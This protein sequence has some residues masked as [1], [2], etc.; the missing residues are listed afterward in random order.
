MRSPFSLNNHRTALRLETLD[1]RFT[2]G[3]GNLDPSFGTG[4]FVTAP[5]PSDDHAVAVA[6]QSDGKIVLASS[7]FNGGNKDFVVMRFSSEGAPDSAFGNNGRVITQVGSGDDVAYALAIQG[8]G[9]IVVA[10]PCLVGGVFQFGVVRYNSNGSLDPSFGTGGKVTTPVGTGTD[11]ASA[12]AIQADGKIV[13]AGTASNGANGFD[14]AAVRYK[15]NGNL[16]STFGSGGKVLTPLNGYEECR[17]A[18]ID[19]DGKI[20]LAGGTEGEF[21][22]VRYNP[23][24]SLDASFDSDGKAVTQIGMSA[25]A[26]ALVLTAD[27]KYL[28]A[29][30][31]DNSFA[32]ARYDP[33]GGLDSSFGENG[34]VVTQLGSGYDFSFAVSLDSGGKIIAAGRSLNG[35]NYNFAVVRY[36]LNGSLDDSFDADGKVITDF[37]FGDDEARAVAI[38]SDGKILVGGTVWNGSAYQ[39]AVARYLDDSFALAPGLASLIFTED[40][41]ALTVD[42]NLKLTNSPNS[43]LVGATVQIDNYLRTE[44]VLGYTLQGGITANFNSLTGL[45]TFSGSAGIADYQAVLQSLSYANTSQSPLEL[46]RVLTVTVND[47]EATQN[48][49]TASYTIHVIAHNDAPGFADDGVLAP[50]GQQ[51]IVLSGQK[52]LSIFYKLDTDPDSGDYF[53]GLAVVGNSA[54]AATQGNWQYSTN[55][56][57]AWF[58]IGVVADDLTA[59]ALSAASRVRFVPVSTFVGQPAPLVVRAIDRTFAHPFTDGA[60][61]QTVDVTSNGETTSIAATTNL[62][63]TE[64]FPFGTGNIP[65]NLL[66]VPVSANINEGESLSFAASANDPDL[67]Q[68]LTFSLDGAPAAAS[69]DPDTGVFSWTTTEADGPDTFVFNVQVTDG[70]AVTARTVTVMVHEVNVAPT[71][72]GVPATVSLVRGQTLT[73]TANA[74]DPDVLNG[75]SNALSFTVDGSPPTITVGPVSAVV[76][77]WLS[78]D[79]RTGETISGTI[80]VSDDGVPTKTDAKTVE[81]MA[82]DCAIVNGDLVI[83]GT[84]KNDT[85]AVKP[86]KDDTQLI[87]VLNRKVVGAAPIANVTGRIVVH[88]LGGNDKITISPKITK[89]ADLHGDIGNDVLKGGGGDDRLFGNADDDRLTGGV[90]NDLLVGGE[91]NDRLVDTVGANVLFGGSG[92]DRLIGGKGQDLLL[93]GPTD[94]DNDLFALGNV[95]AEWTSSSNYSDRIMHLTGPLGGANGTTFLNASTVH[96]DGAKDVLTGAKEADY[97]IVSAL[98]KI[99]LKADEQKLEV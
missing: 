26:R 57:G 22:L 6:V 96:D 47:G 18:A 78:D 21:A 34:T 19:T 53:N 13:V 43:N 51:N 27:G 94:F 91:G 63:E 74:T 84:D 61:R 49:A 16:D 2:P 92:A 10:G 45:L 46:D 29:G 90:G 88:G 86:S 35:S 5:G 79:I 58:D 41:P 25:G 9:K 62:L 8:D 7:S 36:N 67:G 70:F 17:A 3:A 72:S 32:L 93:A 80:R 76:K 28:A 40:D 75:F 14:F 11:Y 65:P 87:V 20:V 4:G 33:N 69:I 30:D 52:L 59:L 37:G 83:G 54:D 56:G 38:Q 73:F 48:L 44:D 15:P 82:L 39:F 77:V 64:V 95:F 23:N 71:L 68:S 89:P 1:D 99:D 12:V 55:N 97:F 66:G 81:I 85:I 98:D 50:V 60:T 24:G 31:S 42:S